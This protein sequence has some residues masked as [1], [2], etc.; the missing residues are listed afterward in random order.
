MRDY[1]CDDL[2]NKKNKQNDPVW[3]GIIFPSHYHK[4]IIHRII[5]RDV[6]RQL[7]PMHG[8]PKWD[9]QD[10]VIQGFDQQKSQ[11]DDQKDR[12]ARGLLFL[13]DEVDCVDRR[14][15]QQ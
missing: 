8:L 2:D 1:I 11:E 5:E 4:S 10:L 7:L 6:W 14:N 12:V 15:R 9:L 13:L 3:H